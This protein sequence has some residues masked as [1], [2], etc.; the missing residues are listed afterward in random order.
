MGIFTVYLVKSDYHA[1]TRY[2]VTGG[3]VS[4]DLKSVFAEGVTDNDDVAISQYLATKKTERKL[5]KKAINTYEIYFRE[6]DNPQP[7]WRKFWNINE[8]LSNKSTDVLVILRTAKA[9]FL[10]VHGH[11]RFLINLYAIE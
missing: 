11:A 9:N 4:E 5:V 6:S 1:V 7:W 3:K 2:Q 10:V 8:Q